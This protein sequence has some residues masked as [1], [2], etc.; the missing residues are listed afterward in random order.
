MCAFTCFQKH[1]KPAG[2]GLCKYVCLGA[3]GRTRTDTSKTLE[4]KSSASTNFAT[5]AF[6][7]S[8]N[9]TTKSKPSLLKLFFKRSQ[10]RPS[11]SL[12]KES[13]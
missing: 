4:P 9:F 7:K 8:R 2:A 12:A 6:L 5:L 3:R 13:Q 11:I 1:K 10:R